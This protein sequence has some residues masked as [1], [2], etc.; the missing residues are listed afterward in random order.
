MN[1]PLLSNSQQFEDTFA[2]TQWGK[3]KANLGQSFGFTILTKPYQTILN[4]KIVNYN[5]ILEF[6]QQK[7]GDQPTPT[8][9]W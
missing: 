5:Q 7:S 6:L 4:H 3:A 1:S 9:T 2:N 8:K